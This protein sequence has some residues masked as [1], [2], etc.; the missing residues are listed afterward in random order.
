M[1]F[2]SRGFWSGLMATSMMTIS[3]FD[4]HRILPRSEKEPLPPAQLTKHM[5]RKVATPTEW[6]SNI[7]QNASLIS[8]FGYGIACG[9]VY[10]ALAPHLRA[11]PFKKGILF[12][13]SVWAASYYGILPALG[14]RPTGPQMSASRNS[15]M[16]LTHVIWGLS[17]AHVENELQQKSR[18]L[19]DGRSRGA[20]S[21]ADA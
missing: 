19:L 14:L 4:L 5:F 12:G 16:F 15:M 2:I 11:S 18:A 21:K 8:H 10:A 20:L 7:Q 6:P 17:L 9:A 1:N 13:T 3:L